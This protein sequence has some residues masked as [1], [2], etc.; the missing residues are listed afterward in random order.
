MPAGT[1]TRTQGALGLRGHDVTEPC[2]TKRVMNT[3]SIWMQH[4]KELDPQM[5]GEV[6][7]GCRSTA[8]QL[9]NHSD[10]YDALRRAGAYTTLV[11]RSTPLEVTAHLLAP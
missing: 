4:M 2:G 5:R 10:V 7:Q 1:Y 9:R 3:Y 6:V 8:A 11:S